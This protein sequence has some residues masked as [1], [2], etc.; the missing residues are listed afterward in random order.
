MY[1][2][3][4]T[5]LPLLCEL[6][7]LTYFFVY[8]LK[9]FEEGRGF[10]GFL[11]HCFSFV[12]FKR[13]IMIF[14]VFSFPFCPFLSC[15]HFQ[16]RFIFMFCFF[17]PQVFHS[18]HSS[19]HMLWPLFTGFLKVIHLIHRLMHVFPIGLSVLHLMSKIR[20]FHGDCGFFAR[21]CTISPYFI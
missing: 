11:P 7:K 20:L 10:G 5:N 1:D 16:L 8:V 4:N 6:K 19:I 9:H 14:L 15:S 12:S 18:A 3:K 21:A 17:S 13:K 2:W